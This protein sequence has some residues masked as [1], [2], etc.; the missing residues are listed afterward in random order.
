MDEDILI[1][2]PDISMI[3][4]LSLRLL[5][6]RCTLCDMPIDSECPFLCQLCNQ[7][8]PYINKPLCLY[9]GQ[10]YTYSKQRHNLND[11]PECRS[12]QPPWH[13]LIPCMYYTLECK[14]LIRQLKFSRQVQ[15]GILFGRLLSHTITRQIDRGDIQRPEALLS[16]PLHRK[17]QRKRGYNQAHV[18]AQELAKQLKVPLISEG[19]LIRVKFTEPQSLQKMGMRKQNIQGAFKVTESLNV[20]HIALIDDVVTTGE[21]I[22]EATE[23]LA[24][25]GVQSIDIWCVARTLAD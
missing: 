17:R 1:K 18:I 22:R 23:V 3:N 4:K 8:L 11:C 7:E 21:T 24:K 25:S 2:L 20:K 5:Q 9:C 6:P 14:Y 19:K 12:E 15:I 16:I 13:H 10:P